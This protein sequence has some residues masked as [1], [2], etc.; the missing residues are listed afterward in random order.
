MRQT[1]QLFFL[2]LRAQKKKEENGTP[3]SPGPAGFP[4][5][6]T[7]AGRKKTRASPSDSFCAFYRHRLRGVAGQMGIY[8]CTKSSD[9][10]T[11]LK[12][13]IR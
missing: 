13:R 5:F 1:L 2:L 11:L 10:E 8:H 12:K 6:S 7:M 4:H 9:P 3:A